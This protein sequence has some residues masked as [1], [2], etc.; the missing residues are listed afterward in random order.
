MDLENIKESTKNSIIQNFMENVKHARCGASH[1]RPKSWSKG[2]KSGSDKRKMREEGKRD[3]REM[4]EEAYDAEKDARLSGYRN[5]REAR[6]DNWGMPRNPNG[7]FS[8]Q[9]REIA[10]M[11]ANSKWAMQRLMPVYEKHG[12]AEEHA[13][14]TDEYGFPQYAHAV[15]HPNFRGFVADFIAFHTAE[16]KRHWAEKGKASSYHWPA[17][18]RARRALQTHEELAKKNPGDLSESLY[19][20]LRKRLAEASPVMGWHDRDPEL[21]GDDIA[22]IEASLSPEERDPFHLVSHE[23]REDMHDTLQDSPD[24]GSHLV[25]AGVLGRISQIARMAANTKSYG[26]DPNAMKRIEQLIDYANNAIDQSTKNVSMGS[27]KDIPY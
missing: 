12:M 23:E 21:E 18:L 4:N 5:A 27:G 2:T 17:I 15:T 11:N 10:R 9:D 20:S 26:D 7:N 1:Q 14:T 6:A 8:G 13:G 22:N 16:N 24:Q 19:A 3:A 25:R